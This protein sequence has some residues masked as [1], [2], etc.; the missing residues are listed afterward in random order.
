[1]GHAAQ[2]Q[3]GHAMGNDGAVRVPRDHQPR[4]IQ[5]EA[6]M[7]GDGFDDTGLLQRHGADQLEI[8][9]AAT[10]FT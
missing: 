5:V 2:A 8:G 4:L 6:A 7:S 1:M 10:H 9:V 3:H